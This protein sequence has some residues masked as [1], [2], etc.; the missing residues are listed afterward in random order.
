MADW[1]V[2]NCDWR[3]IDAPD[4]ID[5]ILTDPPYGLS[6]KTHGERLPGANNR[7]W[8][9][10]QPPAWTKGRRQTQGLKIIGDDAADEG[11]SA[12]LAVNAKQ[13]MVWGM[14]HLRHLLPKG[15]RAIVWDKVAGKPW[16]TGFSQAELLWW[17]EPGSVRV[18][19]HHWCGFRRDIREED[20][21]PE[22]RSH[23]YRSRHP[24][25][26]PVRVLGQLL[27]LAELQPGAVV[28]DPYAGSG[29]VGVAALRRGLRY[30][31]CEIDPVF[32]AEARKR[33]ALIEE[34][35]GEAIPA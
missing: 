24:T 22:D 20:W 8:K 13:R 2:H 5:L 31:G 9:K 33:L 3:D 10:H 7:K 1:V 21:H 15:G 14:D 19:S 23:G 17:S 28:W 27:D 11:V 29:S 25:Q 26:K 35:G 6:I 16:G 34:L 30:I 32:A 12:M 18:I 4:E